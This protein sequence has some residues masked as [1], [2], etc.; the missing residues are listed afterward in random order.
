M[1]TTK[2][3]RVR[4]HRHT[5]EREQTRQFP[6]WI[7]E[8]LD[9]LR[10]NH[11]ALHVTASDPRQNPRII[12][13]ASASVGAGLP[14]LLLGFR[15]EA[16]FDYFETNDVPVLLAPKLDTSW[17]H[18]LP[19]WRQRRFRALL[20]QASRDVASFGTQAVRQRPPVKASRRQS[21]PVFDLTLPDDGDY[22]NAALGE[23]LVRLEP[24]LIY[25]HGAALLPAA[26]VQ[27]MTPRLGRPSVPV[28]YDADDLSQALGPPSD[29]SECNNVAKIEATFA[30]AAW[31]VTAPTSGI[32]ARLR[33]SSKIVVDPLVVA[34]APSRQPN[35]KAPKLR[36]VLGLPSSAPIA[37]YWGSLGAASGLSTV[38]QALASLPHLNLAILA[39]GPSDELI[40]VLRSARALGVIQQVHVAPEVNLADMTEYLS[41]ADIGIISQGV[42]E[43]N[44]SSLPDAFRYFAHAHLPV[45]VSDSD[46]LVAEIKRTRIG[47]IFKAGSAT[48]LSLQIGRVLDNPAIHQRRITPDLLD[49]YA[50][51]SQS[52]QLLALLERASLGFMPAA[53]NAVATA[54]STAAEGAGIRLRNPAHV[55][56]APS[57]TNGSLFSVK[58]GIG[59]ANSAGQAYQWANAMTENLGVPAE[60]FAPTNQITHDPHFPVRRKLSLHQAIGEL[61]RVTSR[62]T[63]L[64]IDGFQSLFGPLFE[65]EL[66]RELD[67]LQSHLFGL[68]LVAHGSDIRDPD[69]HAASV[70]GS[71]FEQ[72]DP[73]WVDILRTISRR[74]RDI[75]QQFE[76]PL[77]VSTPDLLSELPKA[78]WLPVVV[79]GRQW[80]TVKPPVMSERLRVLHQPSRTD[81]P[82]KGT[83]VIDPVL[84]LLADEHKIDYLRVDGIVDAAEMP[85]LVEQCDIVV[86]QIRTGSYG[87]AAA[88]AMM[89]GRIVVGHL[90]DAVR[91]RIPDDAPI[92]DAPASEFEAAMRSILATRRSTL[93][94]RASASADYSLRWHDG[95]VSAQVI[96]EAFLDR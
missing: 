20:W 86:D 53:Q 1:T 67:L 6:R 35:A 79:N 25:V 71:Y 11:V 56:E 10:P 93:M 18:A 33:Q 14:V 27:A 34:T 96:C 89:A 68:G 59:R 37:V 19:G 40:A 13:L 62:Y 74:N 21:I 30:G 54:M 90:S 15:P 36:E 46:V 2:I 58:L 41:S 48:G 63:Y 29:Q 88:E 87:V 51:E 4:W 39:T 3:G 61:D 38:V 5:S 45:V 28:I 47:R 80:R 85:K 73:E 66:S 84:K 50:W 16:E 72:A 57:P 44:A 7:D 65:N 76:G 81:P 42:A 23:V 8:A 52:A 82:I 43:S 75:A 12:K 94:A 95:R 32:A 78:H 69:A 49:E 22:A 92:V 17:N 77:F 91:G 9:A 70:T 64:L 24:R 60:S 55:G 26:A 83:D 31:K